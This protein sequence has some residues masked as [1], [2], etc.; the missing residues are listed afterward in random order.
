V[1]RELESHEARLWSAVMAL[2]A[3]MLISYFEEYK[4][5]VFGP[6]L[7]HLSMLE[8]FDCYEILR[9]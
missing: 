6:S 1:L 3:M 5:K 7:V 9:V 8:V 4:G 2:C